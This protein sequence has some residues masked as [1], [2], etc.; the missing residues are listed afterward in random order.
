M[1]NETEPIPK[2]L[3]EKELKKLSSEEFDQYCSKI[4]KKLV[5]SF[6]EVGEFEAY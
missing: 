5:E 1:M 3:S 6:E 4:I 2:P